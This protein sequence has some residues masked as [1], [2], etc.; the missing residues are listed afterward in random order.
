M[1]LQSEWLETDGLGGFAMGRV[2]GLRTRRYHALLVTASTPPTGRIALVN[3][4]EAWIESGGARFALTTNCYAPGIWHPD[5][6]QHLADFHHEPWPTWTYRLPNGQTIVHEVVMRHGESLVALSWRLVGEGEARL[7]VRPLL[8]VRD[9][10][11]TTHENLSFRMDETVAGTMVTWRPYETMP[12]V[13]A[14]S[15]GTYTA[16]GDWYRNFLLDEDRRR[17]LDFLEDL[18][19]PGFFSFELSDAPAL[20]SLGTTD[21]GRSPLLDERPERCW[22]EVASAE[23]LRRQAFASPLHRAADAYLVRRGE[24]RTVIAGY[25]WFSDW[26]RDTFIAMRGLCLA[27]DRVADAKA[28]LLEWSQHVNEG[29]LPN[30]FPERSG[31]AEYNSVDASLWYVVVV[32]EFLALTHAD[33]SIADADV[34]RLHGAVDAI[35]AGYAGGTRYGIHA[36]DDGLLSAGTRGVQLTWMDAKMGDWVVTPRSGKPVEIQA[37]WINALRIAGLRTPHWSALAEVA[38]ASFEARFWNAEGGYLYDVIDVDH[39]P[40]VVDPSFRPNQLFALGGLPWALIAGE[41]ARRIVD[42]ADQLLWTPAGPRTLS[43]DDP[44]YLPQYAGDMRQRDA[45]YHQG[46]VWPWLAGIFVEAWVRTHGGSNAARAEARTRFLEPLM[47]HYATSGLGHVGE[48]A[49]G[50]APHTPGGCPFQAWSVGEAL[51]LDREI[52]RT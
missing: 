3:G 12:G 49:D 18:G 25:P 40:G 16:V 31:I 41:R 13:S 20:L 10:H 7:T 45:A 39:Q 36:D 11:S 48:I 15:N 28:I 34:A 42:A 17:G 5:G 9:A 26:G 27:G 29:M 14:N 35:V 51:R 8:S 32:H 47:A 4:V 22:G 44:A 23:R 50:G 2:D 38:Q 1:N 6:V 46:T 30:L 43:P 24:G 21:S 19:S 33:H 52:L 37:L